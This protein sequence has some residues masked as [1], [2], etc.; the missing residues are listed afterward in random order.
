MGHKLLFD[1]IAE[2]TNVPKC[3]FH[4]FRFISLIKPLDLRHTFYYRQFQKIQKCIFI[5]LQIECVNKCLT[6]NHDRNV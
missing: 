6:V 2:N 1:L 5:I 3:F 4:V